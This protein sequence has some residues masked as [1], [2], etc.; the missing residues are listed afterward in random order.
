M[1]RD[2]QPL[3]FEPTADGPIISRQIYD[4]LRKEVKGSK[5]GSRFEIRDLTLDD[6]NG[7]PSPFNIDVPYIAPIPSMD[8]ERAKIAD[9]ALSLVMPKDDWQALIEGFTHVYNLDKVK[10]HRASGGVVKF[11]DSHKTYTGQV[12]QEIASW[13]SLNLSGVEAPHEIQHTILSRVTTLFRL[14]LIVDLFEHEDYQITHHNGAIVEDILLRYGGGLMTLPN[15]P[16]GNR[17]VQMLQDGIST[18]RGIVERTKIAYEH[19][20]NRGGSDGQIIFEGSSGT[21]NYPKNFRGVPY[22]M[23]GEVKRR[24]SELT[25]D[26]NQTEDAE[27]IM[28]IPIFMESDP[29][30]GRPDNPIAPTPTAFAFLEPKF[31]KSQKDFDVMMAEMA[32]VGTV[33]KASGEAPY[34]Y[35]KTIIGRDLEPHVV[36]CNRKIKTKAVV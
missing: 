36:F 3:E 11:V 6:T 26:Y 13:A 34:R 31:P 27:R 2:F 24:T 19:I 5:H 12:V 23:I 20:V 16:S 32:A 35:D 29:Y 8:E 17:L 7:N 21:E 28:T 22:S 15:S 30:T 25:T 4:E 33:I 9:L 14:S 18:R 10:E 1:T